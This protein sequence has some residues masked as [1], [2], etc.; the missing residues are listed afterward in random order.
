MFEDRQFPSSDQDAVLHC[1]QRGFK[2]IRRPRGAANIE[3]NPKK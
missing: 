3:K 2:S 1:H